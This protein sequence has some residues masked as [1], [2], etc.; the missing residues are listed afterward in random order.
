MC[1]WKFEFQAMPQRLWF[2]ALA[3]LMLP[4][5]LLASSG[6]GTSRPAAKP[7][8]GRASP[9]PRVDELN[10][11]TMP[12]A[13]NLESKLGINGI[14]VKVFAGDYQRPKT[15]PIKDGTLQIL[16][17][18]GLVGDSFDQTNRCRHLWSFP[19]RDL[20]AY[21]FTTT[22]GTGYVFSLAWGKDQPR[23]DKITVV[24]RYQPPQGPMVYA[25]PSYISI[26]PPPSPPPS[27]PPPSLRRAL[28]G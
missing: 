26:G 1:N 23:S 21:A 22:I 7:A 12:V 15:Q 13:V 4:P 3:A 5:L 10:L 14:S 6:C 27:S 18:D 9:A 16:M 28:P 20:A 11:V 8:P 2:R 24:A 19:G 25:A 17:F